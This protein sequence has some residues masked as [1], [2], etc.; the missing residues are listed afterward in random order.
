MATFADL[1]S[2]V[3]NDTGNVTADQAAVAAAQAK[4]TSDASTLATD[5]SALVS[6][7]SAYGKPVAFVSADGSTVTIY[8]VTADTPPQLQTQVVDIAGGVPVP[9]PPGP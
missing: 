6:A 3:S 4:A 7:L 9:T 8:S 5:T 2:A 1:I